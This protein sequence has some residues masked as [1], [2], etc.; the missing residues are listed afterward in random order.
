[1]S[2]IEILTELEIDERAREFL[3]NKKLGKE[4]E[5]NRLFL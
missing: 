2:S 1:M 4:N 5:K 3:K